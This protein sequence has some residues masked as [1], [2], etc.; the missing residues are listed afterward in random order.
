MTFFCL[1]FTAILFAPS[2]VSVKEYV[3]Q[4]KELHCQDFTLR[5]PY[6]WE[7][8]ESPF[9]D[10]CGNGLHITKLPKTIYESW[11]S[12]IAVT[13]GGGRV[14]S[15]N[16]P[17]EAPFRSEHQKVPMSAFYLNASFPHCISADEEVIGRAIVYV[18]CR[19]NSKGV[20]VRFD[21]S[22]HA[23]AEASALIY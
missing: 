5:V 3:T 17:L 19:N 12:T 10:K 9:I 1:V 22:H 21:G 20:S 13:P 18:Y 14:G 4:P 6:G 7:M 15:A 16:D 23:L 8:G 2:L 11:G